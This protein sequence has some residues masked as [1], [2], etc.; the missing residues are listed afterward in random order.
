M[1][2][3]YSIALVLFLASCGS[4][5]PKDKKAELEKLK[6]ERTALNE[7]IEKLEGEFSKN[8][9]Q[10]EAK[11]VTVAEVNEGLFRNFV[12]V[13]G[14]VDAEDNVEIT[15]ESAGSVVA[16]YVKVG[17]NVG[18]GQVLAQLDDKVLRQNIAQLQTQLDLQTTVFN[19]QKN[20]W[21]QKIGTEI[22]YLTEKSKKEGLQK[23]LSALKSQAAMNKIKSPVAGTVDAMELKLGQSVSP[24]VPT[25]I[26]VVNASR[27]KVKALV[28]ENYASRVNQGD[29]VEVTLPDLSET[30]NTKISFAA[31]VIDPV[32]RGFNVEVKLPSNKTYRPNML[33]TLRIID[34]KNSKAI[35]VP[36]N[37]IQKSETSEYVYI[38]VNGK[39]RKTEVKTGKISDGKAE[40]LNGLKPGDKV[41][42]TGFQELN[43]GD[44]VKI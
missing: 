39:A 1:K 36:I 9:S 43:D 42:V 37:A 22:Q 17:Q 16:I 7:K 13:Q 28:S 27:L 2:V 21:D 10:V 11:E 3:V 19:R 35:S 23:Q 25:G 32:S 38:A 26:R 5:K 40:V 24:G 34:Y 29:E 31:K 33:A 14:K 18:R 30:L 20:L 4:E 8:S 6:K 41:I 15:P 12:E 44:P